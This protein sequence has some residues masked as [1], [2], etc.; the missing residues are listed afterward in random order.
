M[1]III[2]D[3]TDNLTL[4][5]YQGVND[6][7]E[8]VVKQTRGHILNEEKEVVCS[9]FGYTQEYKVEQ[10]NVFEPLLGDV[11]NVTFY[12]A[13]EGSLL[14]LFFHD[15]KWHLSTFKRIN[16]FESRWS[17]SKTFGEL[18][19]DALD[20]FFTNG[21]GKGQLS[22]E[23]GDVFNV[24]CHT[25][26]SSLVYTFLL[27]TNQDTKIV[28]RPPPHPTVFFSGCFKNGERLLN[29]TTLIPTPEVL[30]FSTVDEVCAYV[31][32]ADPLEHQGV[33]AMLPEQTTLKIIHPVNMAYKLIRGSEPDIEQAYFRVRKNP[34]ELEQFKVLFSHVK[35]D[36]IES[37]LEEMKKYLHR[38][39]VRRFIKKLYTIVHPTLFFSMKKAHIWHIE[40]RATNIVT[41]EKI[42]S[43]IDEQTSSSL[44]KMYQEFNLIV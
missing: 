29:N 11:K 42:A 6:N 28:C 40:N 17:S 10:R 2:E 19:I 25:L 16:A 21:A 7:S 39:Y 23:E 5:H 24:F 18:F 20:Y 33:I 35:T 8:H 37:K 26:D 3:Q 1:S 12:R 4:L 13:E 38:M 14:R 9:S 44:F 41:F 15:H 43:I 32:N 30:S 36:V 34:E 31:E 27:R 22:F